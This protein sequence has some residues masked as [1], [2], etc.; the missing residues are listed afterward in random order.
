MCISTALSAIKAL[1]HFIPNKIPW[2]PCKVA[3]S[4]TWSHVQSS[5]PPNLPVLDFRPGSLWE[6]RTQHYVCSRPQAVIEST[7]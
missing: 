2:V 5:P 4:H 6:E 1:V 3:G 7:S